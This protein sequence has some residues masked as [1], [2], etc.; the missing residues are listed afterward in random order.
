MLTIKYVSEG[1]KMRNFYVD[2]DIDG[3]KT[4]VSGG[5]RSRDGEMNI[6]V[7]QR[8]CGES[9]T[10]FTLRSHVLDDGRLCTKVF[11]HKLQC[12]AEFISER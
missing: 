4:P 9:F 3:R 12:V 7:M 1:L 8:N 5:P 11:D 10:A 2:C 6:T